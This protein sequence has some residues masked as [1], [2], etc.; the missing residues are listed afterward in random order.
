MRKVALSII[1]G[2]AAFVGG[3]HSALAALPRSAQVISGLEQLAWTRETAN[4]NIS[5]E[6]FPVAFAETRDFG[7]YFATGRRLD[8]QLTGFVGARDRMDSLGVELLFLS[9]PAASSFED[10]MAA[11]DQL[12]AAI[13]LPE[14]A[15]AGV[16]AYLRNLAHNL[17]EVG[18]HLPPLSTVLTSDGLVVHARG[19]FAQGPGGKSGHALIQFTRMTAPE[20]EWPTVQDVQ[21]LQPSS[22]AFEY[23]VGADVPAVAEPSVADLS[24]RRVASAEFHCTYRLTVDDWIGRGRPNRRYS[25]R[26]GRGPDGRW[27]LLSGH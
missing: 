3:P 15:K 21:A 25:D 7:T 14:H 20:V 1:C 13:G 23:D 22:R 11:A 9:R 5:W 19:T 27:L 6:R 26:F 4:P 17:E 8:A 2:C 10:D 24:C 16:L 12:L 18:A